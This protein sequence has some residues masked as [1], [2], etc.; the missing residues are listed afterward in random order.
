MQDSCFKK[1]NKEWLEERK[2]ALWNKYNLSKFVEIFQKIY[3]A[4]LHTQTLESIGFHFL[5]EAGSIHQLNLAFTAWLF[6]VSDDPEIGVD[7]R[8]IEKLVW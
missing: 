2:I 8:V 4:R 5:E 1:I 7:A 3:E 6:P